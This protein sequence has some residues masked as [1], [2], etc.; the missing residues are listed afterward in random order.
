MKVAIGEIVRYRGLP[1]EVTHIT[2]PEGFLA[3]SPAGR[4]YRLTVSDLD[5]EKPPDPEGQPKPVPEVSPR[6]PDSYSEKEWSEA[7]RRR[8]IVA[9]LAE[10]EHL[11]RAKVEATAKTESLSPAII[12]RWLSVYREDPSVSALV[13]RKR[14]RQKGQTAIDPNVEAIVEGA[15]ADGYLSRQKLRPA[16]I[17]KIIEGECRRAGLKAPHTNTV[18]RRIQAVDPDRALIARGDGEA[19]RARHRPVISQFPGADHPL[20]VIQIDHTPADIIVVDEHH[21]K[22]IGR[23]TLTLAIDVRTRMIVGYCISMEKPGAAAVGQCLY[24]AIAPKEPLLSQLGIEGTWPVA[25]IPAKVLVDNAREF[26]GAML[27]RA[28]LEHGITLEWRPVRRPHFGGHIERLMGTA[29]KEI[30]TLP[31]ATFSNPKARKGYDS[32]KHAAMT[33]REFETWFVDFIVNVYHQRIHKG[34]RDGV[35]RAPIREWED[36]LIGDAD[37]PGIGAPRIPRD[38]ERLRIDLLPYA[39]RTVL[40]RGLQLNGI[41]YYSPVLDPWIGRD[42]D[43]KPAT[44]RNFTIRYDPHDI[45]ALWFLDP[46]LQDYVRIPTRDVTRPAVSIWELKTIRK[47]LREESSAEIDEPRIFEALERN[48]DRVAGS[49]SNTKATR[50]AQHRVDR[51]ATVRATRETPTPPMAAPARVEGDIFSEQLEPFDVDLGGDDT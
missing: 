44:G 7:E 19:V 20:S 27:S 28:C 43:G 2:G 23:P 15:I 38:L 40:P 37:N 14:G 47:Q 51:A 46:G 34:L 50:R 29:A 22:A 49:V 24:N 17:A 48:R 9:P 25:G 31:G 5:A 36:A 13:A 26:R 8:N 12:Y 45:S 41:S 16:K 6:H 30:E 21:R 33:L 4:P 11:T 18:R 42:P 10:C 32:N 3:K 39:M 35:G 1:F